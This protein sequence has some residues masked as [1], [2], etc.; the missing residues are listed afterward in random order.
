[1]KPDKHPDLK[2]NKSSAFLDA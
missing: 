1:M 2:R